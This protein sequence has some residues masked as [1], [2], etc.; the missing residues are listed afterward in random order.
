MQRKDWPLSSDSWELRRC[1][2]LPAAIDASPMTVAAMGGRASPGATTI[3]TLTPTTSRSSSKPVKD[4]TLKIYAGAPHGLECQQ[5][6]L[7]QICWH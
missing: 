5:I 1:S 3:W 6:S 4:A 7:T 2:G